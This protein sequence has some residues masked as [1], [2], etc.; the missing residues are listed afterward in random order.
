M[1]K[2]LGLFF[3]ISPLIAFGQ[4]KITGKIIDRADKKPIPGAS[5]FLSNASAGTASAVDGSFTISN[6]R[7][8]QYELVVSMV[9]YET[10]RQTLLV[11]DNIKLP[12]IEI[13][14]KVNALKEVSIRPDPEW[15]RNYDMFRR[16][17][18]GTS[19]YAR[20]C[21]IIN[22]E[23][24]DIHFDENS[25][26]LT[27]TSL[28]FIEI[29]NKAMGY[30]V[31]YKLDTFSKNFHT[32]ILYYAGSAWFENMPGKKG[33]LS[34]WAKNRLRVY[35]GSSMHFLRSI[36]TDQ[37]PEEGFSILTLVRKPNPDYKGGLGAPYFETLVAHPY[38]KAD[39]FVRRTDQKGLFALVFKD[40]LHVMF[41]GGKPI[42]PGKE[43]SARDNVATN[44]IFEKPFALFD[45]NGIFVDPS[46][47]IFE[48]EWSKARLAELLPVDYEPGAN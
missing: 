25:R 45:N 47:V 3:I 22:P 38:L 24:I 4:L 34:R 35:K 36:I 20:Q 17:F 14:A 13:S 9:G 42:V 11:N 1:L 40:C 39:T 7:G 28:D 19:D 18:L 44:I 2:S 37:L 32:A 15:E 8:G 26:E 46:S 10:F 21:K 23:V 16:E 12:V 6:V 48:G 29:E 27:A 31:K 33:Q 30:R 5:I 43:D 41:N